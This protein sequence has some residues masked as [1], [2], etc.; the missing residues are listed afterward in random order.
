VHIRAIT[1][2]VT[3]K[4][5]REFWFKA[6]AKSGDGRSLAIYFRA[7]TPESMPA[8]CIAIHLM[9]QKLDFLWFFPFF[10]IVGE[11]DGR[12][13][14]VGFAHYAT[15]DQVVGDGESLDSDEKYFYH[16]SNAE[17]GYDMMEKNWQTLRIG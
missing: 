13:E 5:Y 7:D 4:R 15:K 17:K 2:P 14:R 8:E 16:W 12:L 1:T 6:L 3:V 9:H 11:M 10:L